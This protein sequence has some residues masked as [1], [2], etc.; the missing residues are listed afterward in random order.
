MFEHV[1]AVEKLIN[2]CILDNHLDFGRFKSSCSQMFFKVSV[3]KNFASFTRKALVLESFLNV[4][5]IQT[6]NII[7]KRFQHRCFLV[8]FTKFLRIRWRL[9]LCF[10]HTGLF[11]FNFISD[12][13]SV[14]MGTDFFRH[15]FHNGEGLERS[16]SEVI[17][18]VSNGYRSAPKPNGN[19]FRT[20]IGYNS[21]FKWKQKSYK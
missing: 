21:E 14:S 11:R 8:K 1:P 12:R 20:I 16:Y 10:H 15:D 6:C 4:A 19:T 2:K 9:I 3:L 5:D 18:G 7:K 13:P 17:R